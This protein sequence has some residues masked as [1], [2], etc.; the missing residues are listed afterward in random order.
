MNKT[1]ENVIEFKSRSK[2]PPAKVRYADQLDLAEWGIVDVQ[3]MRDHINGN[4]LMVVGSYSNIAH[5]AVLDQGYKTNGK[6]LSVDSYILS[7][8]V[9]LIGQDRPV[10]S[11]DCTN[12]KVEDLGKV[13]RASTASVA[14]G[15]YKDFIEYATSN[16]T[17]L[18]KFST[19]LLVDAVNV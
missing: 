16:I 18:E 11:Y 5:V 8:P 17:D 1:T 13:F 15:L 14:L 9:L 10:G 3:W 7:S 4:R 12:L 6:V 19:K 2:L